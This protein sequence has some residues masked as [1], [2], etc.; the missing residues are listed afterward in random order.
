M[1]GFLVRI[2]IAGTNREASCWEKKEEEEE[3]D[4]EEEE[5]EEEEAEVLTRIAVLRR[6]VTC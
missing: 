5:E 6:A 4:E 3:E 2:K 1:I